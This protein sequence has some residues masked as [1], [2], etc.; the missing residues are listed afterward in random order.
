MAFVTD[1]DN[2]AQG[3][4]VV[5]DTGARTIQ[6]VAAGAL[7]DVGTKATDNGVTLQ[8][9]YS[10]LK[11][12]WRTDATKIPFPFPM[13]AI[14]PEQFEFVSDWEP[15]DDTTRQ[16][17]RTGGWREIAT[18]GAVKREY[19]GIVSLGNIDDGD[20][21]YYAFASATAGTDF[22]FD[23]P[24]NQAIQSFGDALN[25]NFDVRNETLTLFIR[26]PGK[27]YGSQTTVQI[28]VT[29]TLSYI[30]YRFPLSEATDLNI[31]ANDVTI[32]STAPYTGMSI[33]YNATPQA[34]N[35]L[36]ASDLSGGPHNF[37]IIIDA[38]NG[39]KQQVYE[40]VQFQLRQTSSIDA[41]VTG[42][43]KTGT[44]QDAL[45][46]FVGSQLQSL[47]ATNVDGG[48]TGVAIINFDSNDTNDLQFNDNT[49]TAR[50]FPFVAAGSIN[51]NDNLVTDGGAVYR[52]FFTYTQQTAV[53]DLAISG[54]SG[55]TAS[56]D[57]A[58]G[59]FPTLSQNDYIEITGATNPENNG[60]WQVTDASPTTLQFD[61]TKIDGETV[62]NETAFAGNVNENPFGSDGA[63]LV[64]DNAGT[65]IS[66]TVGGSS[67][68]FDFDYD[69]N[70]QGGRTA[71]TDAAITIVAIGL[72]TA[73]YVLA[74][75]TISRAVGQSF[76][77]VSALERNYSNPV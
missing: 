58:G 33:T 27:L 11:E 61:A 45:L 20:T 19:A 47:N 71:G 75:G 9:L 2:L 31:S 21:A 53:A 12:E 30:T 64:D 34:S 56:I 17:I 15:A 43:T 22:D 52:V 51:F 36:Y 16:F 39:T 72:G 73:Q 1:P 23:G 10:F 24:V 4:E 60:V 25:G 49:S 65:D 54:A 74:T 67:I 62:V 32:A 76:S 13:V 77:L 5:I 50:T 7:A 44:L 37:G 57:S 6:L 42:A 48:G 38:N 59:N 69:G 68:A 66:G 18:G 35:V 28:G 26:Q 3:T 41:D 8:A 46:Q 55:S 14:T 70:T 40:F 63:V 29:G